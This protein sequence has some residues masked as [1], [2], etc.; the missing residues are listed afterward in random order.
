[1][2]SSPQA[3]S[4]FDTPVIVDQMPDA[5]A[6]NAELKQLI[7]ERREAD[8]GMGRSNVGGWHSDTEMLRWGGERSLDLV[9][10]VVAAADAF[11]VDIKAEG[12]AR[13][14]WVPEMWA[15]VSQPGASNQFHTHPGAFWSAVYYVDDGYGGS[16]DT[17]LGGELV[18]LDP[19]MPMIRM[20]APDLRFRRP[21][22]RPEDQEKWFR[23]KSGMIVIFPAW[24][25][26]SVRPYNG[27][28]LRISIAINLSA[29]PLPAAAADGEQ[30]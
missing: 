30:G 24:L 9:K 7:L 23:P 8:K 15:N 16:D 26:H 29:A 22:Q 28:D 20:T 18:L 1:M 27:S 12:K 21:G 11:T 2:I 17:S 10:R 25:S 3:A 6:L 4:L 13:F 14:R 5:D 19:R